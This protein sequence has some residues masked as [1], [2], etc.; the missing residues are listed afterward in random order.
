ML[1]PTESKILSKDG[2][3]LSLVSYLYLVSR[4]GCQ[5]FHV[6][7]KGSN[8]IFPFAT[9]ELYCPI[10][11]VRAIGLLAGEEVNFFAHVVDDLA[12]GGEGLGFSLKFQ[13]QIEGIP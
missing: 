4:C 3:E 13:G 7:L 9:N 8:K 1:R 6:S 5:L 2:D 12:G 10:T 11:L